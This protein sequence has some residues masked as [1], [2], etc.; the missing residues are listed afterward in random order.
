MNHILVRPAFFVLVFLMLT[1][2]PAQSNPII[3]N[4]E[5][6]NTMIGTNVELLIDSA[7]SLNSENIIGAGHFTF[8]EK[9]APIFFLADKTLW[10]RFSVTNNTSRKNIFFSVEYPNISL[11]TFYKLNDQNKLEKVIETGHQFDFNTRPNTYVDFNFPL[12]LD[13]GQTGTY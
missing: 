8:S 4:N 2:R 3:Y 12:R 9:K 5:F 1:A 6:P 7:N 11:I 13:S 10:G